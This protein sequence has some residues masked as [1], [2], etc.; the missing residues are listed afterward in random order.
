MISEVSRDYSYDEDEEQNDDAQNE[1][2]QEWEFPKIL[3]R[4]PE[5]RNG[6]LELIK[7]YL[8]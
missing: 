4:V 5:Y 6:V 8:L 3:G 7:V 2:I 1:E